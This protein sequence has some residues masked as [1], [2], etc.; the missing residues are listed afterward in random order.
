MGGAPGLED[1]HSARMFT[2]TL[3]GRPPII[4]S[5]EAS[6]PTGSARPASVR[7]SIFLNAHIPRLATAILLYSTEAW[8]PSIFQYFKISRCEGRD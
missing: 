5:L 6:R 2:I 7:R 4:R 8:E 3:G 1:Q